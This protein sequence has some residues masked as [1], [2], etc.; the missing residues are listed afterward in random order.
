MYGIP[1]KES[2]YNMRESQY[3]IRHNRLFDYY[4]IIPN[5]RT[6]GMVVAT[7]D[8]VRDYLLQNYTKIFPAYDEGADTIRMH[9]FG[10]GGSYITHLKPDSMD[11]DPIPGDIYRIRFLNHE[12]VLSRLGIKTDTYFDIGN[13]DTYSLEKDLEFFFGGQ[14]MYQEIGLRHRRGCLLFGSVGNGKTLGA[15]TAAKKMIEKFNCIVILVGTSHSLPELTFYRDALQDRNVI[16]IV[17]EL[18]ERA[19]EDQE[20]L[21]SFLDGE[22]SW[23]AYTIATTSHEQEMPG[24]LDSLIDRPGRLDIQLEVSKPSREGRYI[25]LKKL[26]GEEPP[27]LIVD[28]TNDFSV[29]Y[30]KELVIRSKLYGRTLEEVLE[31]IKQSRSRIQTGFTNREDGFAF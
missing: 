3:V 4:Y 5:G 29:A 1:T 2:H 18:V 17:E 22:Y 26:L 11:N 15:I 25:Y 12:Y 7:E 28:G 20:S 27:N 9:D 6:V 31:H 14:S 10:T 21:L 8:T 24:V 13:N 16:F 19:A 23:D 30:L